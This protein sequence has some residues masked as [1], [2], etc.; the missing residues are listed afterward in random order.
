MIYMKKNKNKFNLEDEVIHIDNLGIET[1]IKNKYPKL[2][3][4]VWHKIFKRDLIE[5][6][7][8]KFIDYSTVSSEDKLFN[9]ECMLKSKIISCIKEPKYNYY[10]RRSGSITNTNLSK[11]NMVNRCKNTVNYID[12]YLEKN[13]LDID[14]YK[15][16]LNYTELINALSF[17]RPINQIKII[18]L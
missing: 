15:Y 3:H 10:V 5:S 18:N 12:R 1:F 16:Y 4:A 7:N 8:I 13:S 17:T 14:N 2:G 9:L 11:T 6:N